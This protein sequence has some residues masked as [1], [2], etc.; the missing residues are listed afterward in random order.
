M[1]PLWNNFLKN[2]MDYIWEFIENELCNYLN[3]E[4]PNDK[5]DEDDWHFVQD[6][7]Y[8]KSS[9]SFLEMHPCRIIMANDGYYLKLD[10]EFIKL[11]EYPKDMDKLLGSV[12]IKKPLIGT[13]DYRLVHVDSLNRH[14][15]G[16]IR[17]ENKIIIFTTPSG[18]KK[19]IYFE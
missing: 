1:N 15:I 3:I 7:S 11:G 17:E 19:T 4:F 13:T 16:S 14:Y 8:I 18:N 10:D 9:K 6:I 2:N 12:W 5:E